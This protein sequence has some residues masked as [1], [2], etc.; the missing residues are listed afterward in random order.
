MLRLT[1]TFVAV[2]IAPLSLSAPLSAQ[3]RDG[4]MGDLLK[5][6][7]A[8]E[9]KVLDLAKAMPEPAY[10][11]KPSDG[12]R[13]TGEVLMHVAAD[14]Y[15]LPALLDNAPPKD[16]GITKDYKTALA[17]EKKSA[18]KAGVVAELEK[19]FAFLRTAMNST[20][21]AQLNQAV[22]FFG[23]KSTTRGVWIS[24]TTHLH[25]HLGQLIAYARS[26]KV[27]PPWSK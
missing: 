10:A 13:S 3:T 15:L 8:L 20:T 16:T 2:F 24:T 19:S 22:E 12:A 5:D 7:A 6:V 9:K 23:Q 18:S 1:A 25:E 14:N 27:T 17:F 21:D 11:W 26:N 4:V